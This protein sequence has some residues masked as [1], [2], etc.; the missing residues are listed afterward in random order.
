VQGGLTGGELG[1]GDRTFWFKSQVSP[2]GGFKAVKRFDCL[3]AQIA[4]FW[5]TVETRL[6]KFL[7]AILQALNERISI[8]VSSWEPFCLVELSQLEV[9]YGRLIGRQLFNFEITLLLLTVESMGS[10]TSGA[11]YGFSS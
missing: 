6:V 11:L 2:R 5:Q 7:A 4:I 8:L 3:V 9:L 10:Q 1:S